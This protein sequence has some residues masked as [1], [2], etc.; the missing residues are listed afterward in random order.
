M[1]DKHDMIPGV[2][3]ERDSVEPTIAV[4][5]FDDPHSSANTM[6]E[7]YVSGMGAVLDELWATEDEITGVILTSAKKTFFAGGDVPYMLTLPSDAAAEVT[8][9]LTT[10]KSQLRRLETLGRPVV[11]ALNGT[12]LGGG[13][14]IALACHH[15]VAIDDP[16]A[17][18]GLPEV[19]LGLLPGAGGITRTVRM[20]GITDALMNVL[21][22][23]RQMRPQQA[24]A[25]KLIDQVVD[26]PEAMM[27]TARAWI[28]EHPDAVQPW[29]VKGYKIPGGTPNTPA[30]A[31]NLPAYPANLRKQIKGAPMPAPKAIMAAAVEGSLVDVDTALMV[32]TQWFVSLATG[33]VAKNMMKAFFV[34]MQTITRGA[35]RP[36]GVP[37]WR[38]TR[39]AV[40]GAGMMGAGIA[41]VLA[42]AGV[43]VVLKDIS[44]E[45][46][47]KGKGYG[48]KLVAKDVGRGRSTQEQADAL[49]AR[50]T[51]TGDVADLAGCDLMI[52]AVFEDPA[53]KASVY[54]ETEPVLDGSKESGL[55]L[56]SNT[57][58][59][60]ITKLAQGVS[61]PEDFIGL[62]FFSPVDKMP[63]V[64]IVVG[65]QTTDET[66][67]KAFDVVQLIRKTPIVVNDSRG[68]FTSRVISRVMDEAVS[69][70]A[71]GVHPATLEQAALQA[72]YPTGPLALTD[73]ISLS[74]AQG[75]RR[76]TEKAAA[77]EGVPFVPM[78]SHGLID[79]MVDEFGRPGRAGR[80]G[81]Y[82]YAEDGTRQRLWPGLLEHWDI[83]VPTDPDQLVLPWRDI[84]ERMLFIEAIDSQNCLDEGVLR[85]VPEA[86]IGSI[87][88]IAFP[89]WT[90]G[91]LQYIEGYPGGVAGFVARA[92]EL[93]E[94]YGDRFTPPPSLVARA[95]EQ[96]AAGA[97]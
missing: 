46:A 95:E 1:S 53:L 14:E 56:A 50:I 80:A 29:D 15:R 44:T 43:E 84:Q 77:A 92:R 16:K 34:D 69:M 48:E 21:L 61:R 96:S 52:E 54:A 33:R 75:I 94:R 88:G 25:A 59:L 91:V 7:E 72:G 10:V 67:A 5:V 40:L 11:A 87:M 24:L 81:F 42:K 18:F 97:A 57:S 32:E 60:P 47:A 70:L 85:S 35:A 38:P 93:A 36:D 8:E 74:L 51:P 28:A 37:T 20:L 39:A 3:L 22:Q 71:E 66:L 55:L 45:A 12:A 64:E 41:Y 83:T 9:W 68:F 4:I 19:T 86:N 82:D 62:H 58:T 26:S 76:N 89:A 13:L 27:T 23:G 79:R 31:M 78:P 49:L 73:E 90:G 2:R 63:L 17:R 6:N 30:L 65:E